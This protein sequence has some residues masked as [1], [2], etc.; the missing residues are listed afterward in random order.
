M[1]A[2]FLTAY[3]DHV[4]SVYAYLA[5]RTPSREEAEDLTQLT[6][7]RAL[8]AWARFDPSRASAR[9]WL[10]AIARNALIDGRRKQRPEVPTDFEDERSQAHVGLH[11]QGPE[12]DGGV[13]GE[14]AAAI[15]RLQPRE[16][17]VLALRFGGDLPA[18]EIAELLEL[19]L[20]NVHQ[21]TS[22]ALRKLRAELEGRADAAQLGPSQRG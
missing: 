14:L 10:I 4:W 22:R 11:V 8:K 19:T 12:A 17:D 3:E 18:V 1:A 6:F 9:T 5:Y 2:D 21:I 15:G 20:A 13:G 16:Q 7:E